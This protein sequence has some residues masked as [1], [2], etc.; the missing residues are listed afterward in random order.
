M[1]TRSGNLRHGVG[2]GGK[3]AWTTTPGGDGEGDDGEREASLWQ[4]GEDLKR[5]FYSVNCWLLLCFMLYM[6]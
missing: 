2:T 3:V 5:L 1:T 4:L 6:L